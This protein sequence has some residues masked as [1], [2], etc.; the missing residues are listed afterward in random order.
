MQGS[1]QEYRAEQQGI[2]QAQKPS[3]TSTQRTGQGQEQGIIQ[4]R[5]GQPAGPGRRR[6][7]QIG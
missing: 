3:Q 4:G 5:H 6:Q 7:L 2:G 1:G